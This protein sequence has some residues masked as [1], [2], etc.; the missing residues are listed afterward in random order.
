MDKFCFRCAKYK[1][2]QDGDYFEASNGTKRWHCKACLE[3]Y[4][5]IKKKSNHGKKT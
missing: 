2:H 4:K 1:P 5:K 3:R